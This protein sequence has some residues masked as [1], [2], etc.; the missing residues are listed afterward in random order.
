MTNEKNRKLTILTL[1]SE[2]SKFFRYITHT[3]WNEIPAPPA[4]AKTGISEK[5]VLV[6][7]FEEFNCESKAKNCRV[8]A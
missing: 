1:R 2:L 8:I 4:V 3:G 5:M 6:S 7:L